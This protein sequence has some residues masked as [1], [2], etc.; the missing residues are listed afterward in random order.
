MLGA[1]TP[2]AYTSRLTHQFREKGA[3]VTS[4]SDEMAVATVIA[5]HNIFAI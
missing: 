4:V 5:E 1:T 3:Q 2:G